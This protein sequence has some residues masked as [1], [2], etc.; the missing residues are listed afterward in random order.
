MVYFDGG[1]L[2]E[3]IDLLYKDYQTDQKFTVTTYSPTGVVSCSI[4]FLFRSNIFGLYVS[5]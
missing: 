2:S 1:Y 3:L 4:P 5:V